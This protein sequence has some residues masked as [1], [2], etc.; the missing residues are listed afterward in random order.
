MDYEQIA[1]FQPALAELLD[2]F[3][4]CFKR[5][6]TF[7]HWQ[8]YILGLMADLK[9]KSIEPIALSAGVAV[10]TL[11]EFLAFFKWDHQKVE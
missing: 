11:Q 4:H 2:N 5:E 7:G 3:R 6:K 1:S 8:R 9:R 10:R